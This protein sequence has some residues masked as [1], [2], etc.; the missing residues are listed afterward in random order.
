MCFWA[1]QPAMPERLP[2]HG[3]AARIL[4]LSSAT[5]VYWRG[6]G[7]GPLFFKSSGHVALSYCFRGAIYRPILYMYQGR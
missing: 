7:S 2:T 4:Q 1:Q 5:L 6:E 3:Q